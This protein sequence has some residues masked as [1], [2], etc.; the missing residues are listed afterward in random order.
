MWFKPTLTIV[1]AFALLTFK[2]VAWADTTKFLKALKE[3][4]F[5][6][7]S[8]M[9]DQISDVD[10][11]LADGRTALM[12]TSKHGLTDVTEALLRAGADVNARNNNGGT[13]LMYSAIQSNQ[14]IVEMLL[15]HGAEVNVTAK[16]GWTALM[17]M[18]AKGHS[19][20]IERLLAHGADANHRD[21]YQWTPLMR[22]SFAGYHE[23]VR[24]LL[25]HPPTNIDLQ[26]E[27]GA[28]ALHHAVSNGNIEVVTVLLEY[29]PNTYIEDKFGYTALE[30]TSLANRSEIAE[31][32]RKFQY[33]Q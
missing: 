30:R 15:D 4:D 7:L 24:S 32:I 2:S 28:T 14:S 23:A 31:L 26:D 22:A 17:V 25:K 27:N 19:K 5:D 16:F 3:N 33:S 21:T 10:V 20:A 6:R 8:E 29:N 13:P 1:I 11:R 12:L 9:I 18:A